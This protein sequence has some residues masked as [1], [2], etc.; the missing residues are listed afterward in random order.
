MIILNNGEVDLLIDIL[1][2]HIL[3]TLVTST[4]IKRLTRL[5]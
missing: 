3:Y 5:K 1:R 4:Q 2:E